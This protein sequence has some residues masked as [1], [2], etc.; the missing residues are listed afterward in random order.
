M[1]LA[2]LRERNAGRELTIDAAGHHWRYRIDGIRE[3]LA[4]L[5]EQCGF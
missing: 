1:L 5:R 2:P 3:A 4:P